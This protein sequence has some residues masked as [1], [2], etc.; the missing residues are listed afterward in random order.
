MLAAVEFDYNFCCVTREVG[1][2]VLDRYLA[3]KADAVQPVIPEFRPEDALSVGGVLPEFARVPAQSRRYGPR[4]IFLVVHGHLR[5]RE[6]P[7]PAL[8][9]KRERESDLSRGWSD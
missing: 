7:T 9:R 1:D 8:P 5:C 4:R 3:P 2:V 6:T